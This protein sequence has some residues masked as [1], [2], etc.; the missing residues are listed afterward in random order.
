MIQGMTYQKG[1]LVKRSTNTMIQVLHDANYRLSKKARRGKKAFARSILKHTQNCTS[2]WAVLSPR[3]YR[4]SL[5]TIAS[6]MQLQSQLISPVEEGLPCFRLPL[7][8]PHLHNTQ[9]LRYE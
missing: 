2:P 4:R 6:D 5:Y 3:G 9:I 1:W 7:L 8:C